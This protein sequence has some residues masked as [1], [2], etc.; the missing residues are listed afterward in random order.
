[1]SKSL[2]NYING[3]VI[4]NLYNDGTK[5]LTCNSVPDPEYPLHFDCKITNYCSPEKD[6]PICNYCHEMS[7]LNGKHGD[8]SKLLEVLKELPAGT[9]AAVGGGNPLSH[10]DFVPF[11]KE[12]KKLQLVPNITI[13][14]KHVE[15]DF[16]LIKQL[17][18]EKLV[19]GVGISYSQ[20]KYLEHIEKLLPL[21]NNLVFHFIAGL[22][23]LKDIDTVKKSTDKFDKDCKILILGY[24]EYGFGLNY[25]LK[26]KEVEKN[27]YLWMTRLHEYFK[28]N[29]LTLSF[30]NLAISQ[31][32]MKRFFKD[33]DWEK[34]FLGNDGEFSMYID[35]V[36]QE[37]AKSSTSKERKSFNDISIKDYFQ[38]LKK[39]SNN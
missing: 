19:Y 15:K 10:P 31:L 23:S 7:G 5:I 34:F 24:K 16:D 3:N 4:V 29:N 26:N 13:N 35:A 28:Y 9:E 38:S 33:N 17:I 32:R 37:F 22:N 27:K 14:Q 30:D 2:H 1:M 6:N 8:L 20:E 11:L 18:N 12:L 25:Y 36:K 39:I 21:T